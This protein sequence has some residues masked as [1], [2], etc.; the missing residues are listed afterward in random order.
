MVIRGI[1]KNLTAEQIIEEI[2][3]V[4]H[5]VNREKIRNDVVNFL[6]ELEE[7]SAI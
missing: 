2:A 6:S 4:Y 7:C 3:L 1:E 5:G